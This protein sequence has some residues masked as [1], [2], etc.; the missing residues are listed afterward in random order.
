[1][2]DY[3]RSRSTIQLPS[4]S[5]PRY[6]I[7]CCRPEWAKNELN[8]SNVRERW[9]ELRQSCW[10]RIKAAI[11]IFE[12]LQ[13]TTYIKF[14]LLENRSQFTYQT[15]MIAFFLERNWTRN[16]YVQ[17]I[18]LPF[19]VSKITLICGERKKKRPKFGNVQSKSAGF[20]R[21]HRHIEN[22]CYHNTTQSECA[23]F[24]DKYWVSCSSSCMR[25]QRM[26]LV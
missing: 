26:I 18:L 20:G 1:M 12:S 16:K 6:L 22:Y 11:E 25:K 14:C 13:T 9:R 3:F 7:H 2:R 24:S 21:F 8:T 23:H 15:T 17:K 5:T 19:S 10:K 4:T